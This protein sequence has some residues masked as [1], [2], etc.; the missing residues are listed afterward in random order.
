MV[1]ADLP[2]REELRVV[3]VDNGSSD[4]SAAVAHAHGAEVVREERRGYGAACLA[5]IA[6]AKGERIVAFLDAD[7]SDY[8]EELPRILAPLREECADLVIGSRMIRRDARRALLP[9]AR[10]GN[11]VAAFV[12]RVLFG[13]PATDLGPFRAIT[14]PALR[15]LHMADR[16]FGWTVEMQ[17]K[18][19]L[20]GLR[21]V[22]VPVRYR[23]RRGASKITGTWRGTIGAGWKILYTL[24]RLRLGG[25]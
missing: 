4:R 23:K 16:G 10:Y 21:T 5:G 6:A 25:A 11:R 19:A 20:C 3:V 13:Q 1:L 22:E 9:Q 18:A 17:A 8:P 14:S 15:Q 24:F 12:L 2:H 7:Y